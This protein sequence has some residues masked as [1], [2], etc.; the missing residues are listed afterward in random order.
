[1]KSE[2][3]AWCIW[4]VD[5]IERKKEEGFFL[6]K[7]KNHE[8]PLKRVRSIKFSRVEF[9]GKKKLYHTIRIN[10]FSILH[11]QEK[12]PIHIQFLF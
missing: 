1:M 2:M 9:L 4:K 7:K 3:Y 12:Y 11:R 6:K 8:L 5:K 10:A